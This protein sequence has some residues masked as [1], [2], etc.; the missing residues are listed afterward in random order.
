MEISSWKYVYVG[1]NY[2]YILGMNGTLFICFQ[3]VELV[4]IILNP[5]VTVLR[6]YV[7]E[8]PDHTVN[9]VHLDDSLCLLSRNE[10][11]QERQCCTLPLVLFVLVALAKKRKK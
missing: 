8:T 11:K 10:P 6:I 1:R 4:E 2:I 9:I 5:S 7:L 3:Y